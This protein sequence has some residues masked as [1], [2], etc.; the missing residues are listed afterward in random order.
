MIFNIF[1]LCWSY[2]KIPEVAVNLQRRA[3]GNR[4]NA[5]QLF[6]GNAYCLY[7]LRYK[8]LA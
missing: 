7:W 5:K 8:L 1:E 2:F 6:G 4:D 3:L